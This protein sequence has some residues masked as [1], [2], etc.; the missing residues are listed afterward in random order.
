MRAAILR[1]AFLLLS[2]ALPAAQ[3][4]EPP[5]AD[6]GPVFDILEFDISGNTVLANN[7]IENAV[8]PYLGL[9]REVLDVEKARAALERSYHENGYL[10]VEVKIPEQPVTEGLIRLQVY[11]GSVERLKVSGNKYSS[12]STLR[13]EV[14]SLAA[15]S[16][17][18]YPTMQEEL[19]ELGRMSDRRVTPLLRPGQF[20]GKMEVELA[21]EEELPFHG[22]LE[23]NNK[24]S[25]DTSKQRLEASLRYDNLFQRGHS[26]SLFYI[27][28]PEKSN[29]VDVLLAGYRVPLGQGRSLSAYWLSA[30]SNIATAGDSTVIGNGSLLG[31][32]LGLPLLTPTGLSKTFFHSL[33]LGFDSKDF[34]ERQTVLSTDQKTS[35]LRYTPL[36]GQY[37]FGYFGS[38]GEWL[39]NLTVTAGMRGSSQRQVECYPGIQ[40]EQFSC[41]RA[42]AKPNFITLRGDLTY[43]YRIVGWEL[44][45]RGDF[46]AAGQP[47]VSNE[48]FVAGGIDS[49]RGYFEGET[50]GDM[51]W[52][53][54]G[55]IKTPSLLGNE[56]TNLRALT[57]VDAAGLRLVDPLPGQQDTWSLSSVGLGV[58]VKAPKGLQLSIDWARALSNG[59]NSLNG[60]RTASG[61]DRI[62]VRL[63]TS[64]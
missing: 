60:Y 53:L 45:A 28:A 51:G 13:A 23:L 44:L 57:F 2:L 17:P 27:T 48:Q 58:R 12:R 16:V 14:P 7:V 39:G 22:S 40:I 25:P 11:E 3:A 46:Q 4:V 35:P 62:H 33:S 41:R 26:A 38:A 54:R 10:S 61:S 21:V 32:R 59:A 37:S 36:V 50:A 42:G 24:Q 63:G 47:L 6:K 64:F 20:P 8:Y 55:E 43:T 30:D 15:G 29:E 18:H 49:V 19:G 31:M 5:P 34:R 9:E 52:R 56:S 1:H